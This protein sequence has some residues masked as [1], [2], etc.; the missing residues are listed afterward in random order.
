MLMMLGPWMLRMLGPFG[1]LGNKPSPTDA[2]DAGPVSG[3]LAR[4]NS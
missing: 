1:G 4:P 3:G 2:H